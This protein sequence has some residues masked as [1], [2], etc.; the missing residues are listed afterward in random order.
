MVYRKFKYSDSKWCL[1]QHPLTIIRGRGPGRAATPRAQTLLR[2]RHA[3]TQEVNRFS[4]RHR[5]PAPSKERPRPAPIGS[6]RRRVISRPALCHHGSRSQGPFIGVQATPP[7]APWAVSDPGVTS[8]VLW[9]PESEGGFSLGF[10]FCSGYYWSANFLKILEE[11]SVTSNREF[12]VN[13]I[14]FTNWSVDC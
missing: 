1:I 10:C 7:R 4:F 8:H 5:N 12:W 3:A 2:L 9:T 14:Y 13:G 11:W 6:A